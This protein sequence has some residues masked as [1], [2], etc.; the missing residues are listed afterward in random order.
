MEKSS[1]PAASESRVSQKSLCTSCHAEA[2]SETCAVESVLVKASQENGF[3]L[4]HETRLHSGMGAWWW[5]GPS[6]RDST[7]WPRVNGLD[8]C[9]GWGDGH[10]NGS[11]PHSETCMRGVW[12]GTWAGRGA[13]TK[14]EV[15]TSGP[16][17]E[18]EVAGEGGG[19]L[20]RVP[21]DSSSTLGSTFVFEK[22]VLF[23]LPS[24]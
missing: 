19:P 21:G 22:T 20:R 2:F 15:P 9:S 24:L 1:S 11:A 23:I 16:K 14:E 18:E 17:G 6:C 3:A 8:P 5:Q 10:V 7:R 13:H 4:M 12:S